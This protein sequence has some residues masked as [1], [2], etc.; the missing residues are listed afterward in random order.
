MKQVI[1]INFHGRV[2]PIEVSA[3]EL[4]KKYT[5]SLSRYFAG[6]EGKEE[7]INDIESRI[8]ELF[9]E[10][11]KAGATCITDDD[12]NAIIKSIGRAEDFEDTETTTGA[13][14]KTTAGTSYSTATGVYKRLFRDENNK[15]LGGVCSGIAAYFGIDPI[16]VRIIAVIFFGVA[17]V[18]YLILWA[19][20]PGA[21][22]AELGSARKKL[23]RDSDD[24]IIAGVCSGLAGY[25][26]IKTWIPRVI[27]L[28]PL[29]SFLFH[30]NI[31]HIHNLL[32]VSFS[33]GALLIYII[34]WLVVPE[35][36][37]TAEKLEMKGEKVDINSIKN[38]VVGE[39]KEVKERAQK[40]AAEN[41][42]IVGDLGNVAKKTSRSLGDIIVLILKIFAYCIIG[43]VAFVLVIVLLA[44]ALAAIGIFPVLT[45]FLLTTGWQTALAW[46]TLLF[47]ISVP[48]IGV[49]TWIIRRFS[50][51][52]RHGKMLNLTFLSL[53]I[54]GWACFIGLLASVHNDF[55]TM[56]NMD[57]TTIALNNPTVNKL[58]LTGIDNA[59]GYPNRNWF[60]LE[61]FAT[62]DADT[63]YLQNID[64]HILPST[65][66]SFN[67]VIDKLAYGADKHSADVMAA[68][69]KFTIVQ[70][71]SLLQLDK[72]I[73][74]T[75]ENKFRD[76]RIELT[77]YVPVGKQIRIDKNTGGT[78]DIS[79]QWF[80][81]DINYD[82]DKEAKGWRE[83][84]DYIMKADGLY[85]LD[86]K[87]VSASKDDRPINIDD[88][89][90]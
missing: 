45:D 30:W 8:G 26:G 51:A 28:I 10:R 78:D 87:Q 52:K 89:S 21:A 40:F 66:D 37:T 31:F 86:G 41:K 39:M 49:I 35:A 55:K 80:N 23:Y 85:T 82:I 3:F 13:S 58:E 47:F 33:P 36:N 54:I 79:V 60:T 59:P 19:I 7:I 50:K 29:L 81:D 32:H 25:F 48:V 71:D 18:P 61:P 5:D 1:N 34:L 6:E 20:V 76:Q 9:H 27:F 42:H 83:N 46:G 2:I 57:E 67:V 70:K 69:I 17:F 77:V 56:N 16:I 75:R 15:V 84:V 64:I 38:S 62:V 74:I 88:D 73:A 11:L 90:D 68:A 12:V 4:L 72:G 14:E 65:N 24:K 53:W 43:T 22:S 44:I 63:V